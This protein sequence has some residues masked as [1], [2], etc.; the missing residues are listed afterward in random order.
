MKKL[1]DLIKESESNKPFNYQATVIVEGVV[2]SDSE[3]SAGELVDKE[4]DEIP[5]MI[6]YELINISEE[7][8]SEGFTYQH[9]DLE[10]NEAEEVK[11]TA[12]I[13]WNDFYK[14]YQAYIDGSLYEEFDTAE[15]GAEYL[16]NG[17]YEDVTTPEDL[18]TETKIA[19]NENHIDGIVKDIKN[20]RPN[21]IAYDYTKSEYIVIST[22]IENNIIKIKS[23]GTGEEFD[24]EYHGDD[25]TNSAFV[26]ETKIATNE[27][28]SIED[29]FNLGKA[30]K[31]STIGPEVYKQSVLFYD[32][33]YDALS[34]LDEKDA[35]T[36]KFQI[37]NIDKSKL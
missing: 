7:Q 2:Y 6:S 17:G 8:P 3:G 12:K 35:E 26:Y 20:V 4:M 21:D 22:D 28:K 1:T 27:Q 36:V 18:A 34:K 29:V 32:R 23:I 11:T 5:G 16:A 19:T 37:D 25:E 33:Y 31:K 30:W 14:K 13:V 24:V 15:Q 10:V 9:P